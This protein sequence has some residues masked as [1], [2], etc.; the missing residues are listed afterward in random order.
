MATPTPAQRAA[1]EA[2]R[3]GRVER[4]SPLQWGPRSGD[5][6]WVGAH[7]RR[8]VVRRDVLDRCARLGLIRVGE[9]R[10]SLRAA[11]ELT[12]AGREALACHS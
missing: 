1:L 2:V 8:L 6:R 12:D 11:V 5:P 7:L 9:K 3:D 4:Y 10:T